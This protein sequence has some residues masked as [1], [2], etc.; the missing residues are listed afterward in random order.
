[1]E[2]KLKGLSASL[3]N[4]LLLIYSRREGIIASSSVL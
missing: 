4:Y 3:L 1:M 2:E